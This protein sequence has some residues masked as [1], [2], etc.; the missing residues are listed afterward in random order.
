MDEL[1]KEHVEACVKTQSFLSWFRLWL[2]LW[3]EERR[4]HRQQPHH[5]WTPQF[6]PWTRLLRWAHAWLTRPFRAL[7]RYRYAKLSL[8]ARTAAEDAWLV[9]TL[10]TLRGLPPKTEHLVL[11]SLHEDRLEILESDFVRFLQGVQ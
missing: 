5:K 7:A 3:L 4:L 10:K 11:C 1:T 6:P 9:A 8:E 2:W